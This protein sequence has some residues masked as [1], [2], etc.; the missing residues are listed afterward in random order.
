MIEFLQI[1]FKNILSYGNYDTVIKL[2][3]NDITV[4][5][6][7]NGAGKS[8][9]LDAMSFVLFGKPFR[10][11]N[12]GRLV[13]SINNKAM[14]VEIELNSSGNF[15][16]IVRGIK[17]NIFE[18]Y[19]NDEML[20]I[21]A[22]VVDQQ[23]WLEKNILGFNHKS[24]TQLIV[25]GS[26]T[27]MPF[28]QLSKADR[29]SVI[30]DIL[31]INVLSEMLVNLKKKSGV[32]RA[33]ISDYREFER[34]HKMKESGKIELLAQIKTNSKSRISEIDDEIKSYSE[35]IKLLK[36]E[37]LKTHEEI[38]KLKHTL[39]QYNQTLKDN[40]NI[41]SIIKGN[42]S[43]IKLMER[44]LKDAK[45]S[46][47]G[48]C[49]GDI[50]IDNDKI[51]EYEKNINS[52]YCDNEDLQIESNSNDD[53]ITNLQGTKKHYDSLI[54]LKTKLTAEAENYAK[55]LKSSK[56]KK[57]KITED[58]GAEK[59]IENEIIEIRKNLKKNNDDLGIRQKQLEHINYCMELLRDDG[60]KQQI[61]NDYLPII[62]KRINY[63][64]E[65]MN[66]NVS[67]NLDGQFEET[68]NSRHRD[69]FQYESFSE[70]EKQRIDLALL[71][72]WRDIAQIRNSANTNLL[73]IDEVADGSLDE[74]GINDFIQI[75]NNN[76]ENLSTFIVT[77]DNNT[78]QMFNKQM[79]IEKNKGFSYVV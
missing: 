11:I 50:E 21:F 1:K 42:E 7:K 68:I 35:K 48:T 59:D 64:L 40:D 43:E 60:V 49:G 70:G 61:L 52:L 75:L 53:Y 28:M 74:Q 77:H 72:T 76:S 12:K 29:R 57:S 20:N 19:K 46:K 24:M 41:K 55:I 38:Q 62:N 58:D 39:E 36:F 5:Y 23:E 47:C 27:F 9:F 71:F 67:F 6:G 66:F 13:N 69:T 17:P 56:E 32:V 30:E 16:K 44:L 15:Y 51:N 73:V 26:A 22:N 31:E 10:K 65:C 37:F 2:N 4:V 33:K 78:I 34:I 54:L 14:V 79:L 8:T 18:I 3:T 45:N 25:L 63:Y